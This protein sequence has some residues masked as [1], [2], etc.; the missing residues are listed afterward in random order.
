MKK[1]AKDETREQ[2]KQRWQDTLSS[3]YRERANKSVVD[4]VNSQA[5]L[6]ASGLKAETD[7]FIIAAQDQRLFTERNTINCV[8]MYRLHI[9]L[10]PFNASDVVW[11]RKIDPEMYPLKHS[12]TCLRSYRRHRR[13]CVQ[14]CNRLL[15]IMMMTIL[16]KTSAW[17]ISRMR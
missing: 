9:E 4:K 6:R 10:Y 13:S 14:S 1:K 15:M 2:M 7:S 12:T 8:D 3:Q 16:I 5:W 17:P 11:V